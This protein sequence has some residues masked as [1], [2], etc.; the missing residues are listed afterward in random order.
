MSG[1]DIGIVLLTVAGIFFGLKIGVISAC[2]NI[3]AGFAGTWVASRF[4]VVLSGYLPRPAFSYFLLFIIVAAALVAAGILISQAL[5]SY[6]LGL[7]DKFL[8]ALLGMVLSLLFSSV[9]LFPLVL[10]QTPAIKNLMRR[11]AFAPYVIRTTQRYGRLAAQ[12]VWARVEPL[13]ESDDL[14]RVR[15]LLENSPR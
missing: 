8:G 15:K 1:L 7:V 3:L 11:S 4:Y 10:E 9:V 14:R 2:F 13:L 12:D 5:E 6:F